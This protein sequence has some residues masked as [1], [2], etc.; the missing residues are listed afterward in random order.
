VNIHT[1]PNAVNQLF[2]FHEQS[3]GWIGYVQPLYYGLLMFAQAA[4]PGSRL[5]KVSGQAPAA[6]RV[7]GTK[8]RD[9][10]VRVM[11]I[12]DGS[13]QHAISFRAPAAPAT[14]A[15]GPNATATLERL[16]APK[17]TAQ[18]GITLGGQSFDT[19]TTTGLLDGPASTATITPRNGVYTVTLPPYSATLVTA[20]AH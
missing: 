9:G 16:Q 7:W 14:G 19:P 10:S 17:V 12:N 1:F 18:S 15:A 5:L 20:G 2:F 8:A 4:P 3:T 6:V 13:G 11:L